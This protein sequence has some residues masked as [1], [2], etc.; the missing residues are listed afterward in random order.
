MTSDVIVITFSTLLFL[1][2]AIHRIVG[3]GVNIDIGDTSLTAVDRLVAAL[4]KSIFLN[5]LEY[6]WFQ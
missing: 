3:S 5:E 4:S 6:S 1:N 2:V